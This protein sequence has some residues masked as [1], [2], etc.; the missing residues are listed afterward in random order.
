MNRLIGAQL[1]H[2]LTIQLVGLGWELIRAG[3]Y[4][5]CFCDGHSLVLLWLT[6]HKVPKQG[7]YNSQSS[8]STNHTTRDRTSRVWTRWRVTWSNWFWFWLWCGSGSGSGRCH[9]SRT[10]GNTWLVINTGIIAHSKPD[11]VNL[12][13][14]NSWQPIRTRPPLL[15]GIGINPPILTPNPLA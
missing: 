10:L 8:H 7:T 5:R 4:H 15:I 9:A 13:G 12:T 1:C 2:R 6:T 14:S 3:L 11:M